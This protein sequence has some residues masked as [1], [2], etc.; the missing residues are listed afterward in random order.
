[1][2]AKG[3]T[4]LG[5]HVLRT[6]DSSIVQEPLGKGYHVNACVRD[7]SKTDR[8]EHLQ[9]MR[10]KNAMKQSTPSEKKQKD[11]NSCGV[12]LLL[13]TAVMNTIVHFRPIN[14]RN[15]IE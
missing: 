2:P 13:M 10:K 14:F 12:D 11:D 4:D 6:V 8:V 1:M 9:K 3:N 15:N 7:A 5:L